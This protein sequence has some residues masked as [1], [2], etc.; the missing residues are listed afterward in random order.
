MNRHLARGLAAL[1][2]HSSR[3]GRPVPRDR[4]TATAEVAIALPAVM[5]VLA[6]VLAAGQVL[7]AQLRCV[8]A[9][10]GAARFV[11]RGESSARS[12]SEG[13]RLGPPGSRVEIGAVGTAVTVRV[14]ALVRLPGYDVTVAAVA[15]ADRESP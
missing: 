14:S 9:A 2:H 15:A 1:G 8:D 13:A 7:S 6:A 4:G 11:A 3:R 5:V 10:H 12:A